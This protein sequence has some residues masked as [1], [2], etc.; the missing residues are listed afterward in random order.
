MLIHE[1]Y[2]SVKEIIA[3]VYRD[4]QLKDTTLWLD[5]IEWCAEALHH[6]GQCYQLETKYCGV[7]ITDYRGLIPCDLYQIMPNGIVYNGNPL[8]RA[9]GSFGNI[10]KDT[11]STSGLDPFTESKIGTMSTITTELYDSDNSYTIHFPYINTSFRD[12][13]I[14]IA[15]WGFPVDSDGYPEVPDNISYKEALYRYIV[16][17]LLYPKYIL[18]E[19]HP[20]VYKDAEW[21]WSYY[22]TQAGNAAKMPDVTGIENI[23][24]MWVRLIPNIRSADDFYTNQSSPEML[25]L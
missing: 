12:G 9:T 5:M 18:G 3:K 10:L 17:K 22:C 7:T 16:Y 15:Y 19:I 23:R 13:E 21:Q 6:I 8:R 11:S 14:G 2:V 25:N 1:K 4:L 24:N 20:N